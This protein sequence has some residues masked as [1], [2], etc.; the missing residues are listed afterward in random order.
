V[1]NKIYM[2]SPQ[3]TVELKDQSCKEIETIKAY[4][5][6]SDRK[7]SG[8]ERRNA[9]CGVEII[10]N[11]V[12]ESDICWVETLKFGSYNKVLL[13][14]LLYFKIHQV[15]MVDPAGNWKTSNK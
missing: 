3:N 11:M 8:E 2:I 13:T 6:H 9:C 4:M 14:V 10:C 1:K 12:S 5:P 15:I 7:T